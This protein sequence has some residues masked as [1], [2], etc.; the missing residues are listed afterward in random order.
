MILLIML[1]DK[2]WSA[3]AALLN[4]INE[5]KERVD[6]LEN[7]LWMWRPRTSTVIWYTRHSLDWIPEWVDTSQPIAE[8]NIPIRN[9]T[10]SRNDTIYAT[11]N[12]IT[13]PL[14]WI[15]WHYGWAT[16]C[17]SVNH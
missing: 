17:T 4:Q 9:V 15:N 16:Y 6:T 11:T 3:V 2:E 14:T 10:V 7:W 12:D 8:N 13:I 1:K 5:L